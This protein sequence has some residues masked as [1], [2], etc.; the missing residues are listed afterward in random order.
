MSSRDRQP[1]NHPDWQL[2]TEFVI[3]N[4]QGFETEVADHISGTLSQFGLEPEHLS[5]ILP[6]IIRSLENSEGNS[7][8]LHLRVSVS[9]L[10]FPEKLPEG[11]L[12]HWPDREYGGRG[13]GFF[14][15]KRIVSQLQ[16]QA[17]QKYRLLE[18]LI[19]RE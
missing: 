10:D 3:P 13:L 7:T 12:D 5:Q 9:G 15:V 8:P 1:E 6:S 2:L 19:Y 14:L 11:G 16:E 4:F 18:V 17:P